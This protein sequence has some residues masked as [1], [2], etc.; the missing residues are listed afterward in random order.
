MGRLGAGLRAGPPVGPPLSSPHGRRE[1]RRHPLNGLARSMI[2]SIV[3]SANPDWPERSRSTVPRDGAERVPRLDAALAPWRQGDCVV[4][5]QWFV[6]RFT[7]EV[8]LTKVA[9][10]AATAGVDLAE[11]A[12]RGFVVVSQTCDLARSCTERPYV[13]VAPLV[14]VDRGDLRM[15]ERGRRPRYA[16]IPGLQNSHLV[17][18]LDRVMTVEKAVVAAWTRKAG[19]TTDPEARDF[20]RALARKRARFAFPD[21]FTA[22]ANKLQDRLQTKHDKQSD[23]GEALRALREIRV[24]AAPSWDDDPVDVLFWFLRNEDEPDFKGQGWT[25]FWSIG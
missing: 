2:P 16:F 23:E 14:E 24:R 5:A 4:G 7:P 11:A 9:A 8:P 21:D 22:F 25:S 20:A 12:V 3:K 19:C 13:E 6:H 10:E 15:I 17:G 1:S 18:D